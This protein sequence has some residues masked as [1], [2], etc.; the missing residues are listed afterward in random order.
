MEGELTER[1]LKALPDLTEAQKANLEAYLLGLMAGEI[2]PPIGEEEIFELRTFV[3][4]PLKFFANAVYGSADD[5]ASEAFVRMIQLMSED[6]LNWFNQ[7]VGR[8][9]EHLEG[10][11]FEP[12]KVHGS[13][14]NATEVEE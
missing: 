6:A 10:V 3:G 5:G 9:A 12:V 8:M 2:R 4:Q 11:E 1:I 14:L 13:Q 7:I